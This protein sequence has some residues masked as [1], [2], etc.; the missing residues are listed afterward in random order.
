MKKYI[1]A[2]QV[3]RDGP[4]MRVSEEEGRMEMMNECVR[5][6]GWEVRMDIVWEGRIDEGKVREEKGC[7]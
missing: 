3:C 5:Y 6:G 7:L 4:R 1:K 2:L